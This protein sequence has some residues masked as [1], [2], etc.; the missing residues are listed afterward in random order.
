VV[1]AQREP[2]FRGSQPS[3]SSREEQ[4][5]RTVQRKLD[6]R[7]SQQ[8]QRE[9][10][11]SRGSLPS[12][13]G[14]R[15]E[16]SKQ[17]SWVEE[18]RQEALKQEASKSSVSSMEDPFVTAGFASVTEGAA[19]QEDWTTGFASVTED[20]ASQEDWRAGFASVTEGA[21]SQEDWSA[22]CEQIQYRDRVLPVW[23]T[24]VHPDDGGWNT[25]LA[26]REC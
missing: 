12:G 18:A 20:A 7:G 5:P 9:H 1:Q 15:E 22:T 2:E 13:T 19:S 14:G 10:H 6:F 3:G 17:V 16:S 26:K 25:S 4:P 11:S 23:E 24:E 8:A 21:T